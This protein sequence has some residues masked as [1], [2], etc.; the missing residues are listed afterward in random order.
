MLLF[1]AAGC[2]GI[3]LSSD[4]LLQN[5][6]ATGFA[7]RQFEVS[8]LESGSIYCLLTSPFHQV[9]PIISFQGCH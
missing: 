2:W 5:P 4:V 8:D 3:Q 1:V 6:S 7:G 9:F